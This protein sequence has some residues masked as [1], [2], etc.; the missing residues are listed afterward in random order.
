[1][2]TS[3]TS[4]EDGLVDPLLD[5][6]LLV[7]S[8]EDQPGPGSTQ[9]LV[10]RRGDNVTEVE[11]RAVL[12]RGDETRDVSHVAHQVGTVGIGNL[13]EPGIVPVSGVSRSSADDESG[14]VQPGVDLQLLVVD[15][16]GLRVDTVRER[17]EVDRRRGD[18]LLGGV[19]TV[20]QVTTVGQTETHDPVL[21]VDQGGER[22]K[23]GGGSRVRLDVDTPELGVEVE[24]LEGTLSAQ[25]LEDVD[26]LVSS[27]VSGAGETF[28]VLVGEHRSV[29]LHNSQRGQVL[30]KSPRV[31][32]TSF[33]V[34]F[35]LT[36]GNSP[37]KRSTRVRKTASKSH[38]R[39]SWRPRGQPRR[40][41]CR[42][43]C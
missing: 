33:E 38:P 9:G 2:R 20:G 8:E 12:T 34:F 31:S 37:R 26:V 32:P 28:R 29:G 14:L 24:G 19:V 41:W 39:R 17:L 10:R 35:L 21:R 25:V 7:L 5:I 23:V 15:Q 6:G 11:R 42:G 22:G 36:A 16:A 43:T 27:V 1:M 3:L 30:G 40:G 13:P 4:G 18:L